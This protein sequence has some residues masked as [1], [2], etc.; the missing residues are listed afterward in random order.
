M[1]ISDKDNL[2]IKTPKHV[3]CSF[4]LMKEDRCPNQ[5]RPIWKLSWQQQ[6]VCDENTKIE[7]ICK[8][9]KHVLIPM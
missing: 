6:H 9:R 5:T 7:E 1:L 4:S 8:G 3:K 2:D